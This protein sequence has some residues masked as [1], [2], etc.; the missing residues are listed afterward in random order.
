MDHSAR[1]EDIHIQDMLPTKKHCAVASLSLSLSHITTKLCLPLEISKV[2]CGGAN[3]LVRV[4]SARFSPLLHWPLLRHSMNGRPVPLA[5]IKSCWSD[6][7]AHRLSTTY[8]LFR[9]FYDFVRI[10][11]HYFGTHTHTHTNYGQNGPKILS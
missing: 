8:Y 1:D 6:L 7:L 11:I 4:K 3:C 9:H 5:A 2:F 10:L